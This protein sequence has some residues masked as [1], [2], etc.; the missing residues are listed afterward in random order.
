[1]SICSCLAAILNAKFLTAAITNVRQNIVSYLSVDCG[2]RYSSV[3][4]AIAC[5]WCEIIFFPRSEVGRWLSDI[6]GTVGSL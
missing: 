6:C 2:V 5:M 1:M 3:T 4:I